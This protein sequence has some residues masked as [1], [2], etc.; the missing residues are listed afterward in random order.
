MK[1][2]YIKVRLSAAE[3]E[4]AKQK[5]KEQERTVSSFIRWLI[6]KETREVEKDD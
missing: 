5:A 6:S 3:L 2:K 4:K 1:D